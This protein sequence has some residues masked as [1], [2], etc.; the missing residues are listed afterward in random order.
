MITPQQALELL[1]HYL[2][3]ESRIN[4]CVGVSVIAFE[5]ANQIKVRNPSLNI[6][7]EKIKIAGLLH[8]IGYS[9]EGFH[10]TNGQKILINE[11]LDEIADIIMHGIIYEQIFLQTGKYDEKYLPLSVENK[12]VVLADM[13]CNQKQQ[14]VTLDERIA[15]IEERYKDDKDFLKAARL[16]WPRFKRIEKEIMNL[17]T[18]NNASAQ[19]LKL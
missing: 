5:L 4:H 7:P 18:N 1:K 6:N 14:R 9:K 8:D 3:V 17:C 2:K 12:I 11:G 19:F 10:E 16:A 13:Y 15:D